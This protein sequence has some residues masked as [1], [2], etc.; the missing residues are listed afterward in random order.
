ME[1]F[2]TDAVCCLGE[3]TR[4]FWSHAQF[5]FRLREGI[6]ILWSS[7]NKSNDILKAFCS[8]CKVKIPHKNS[9]A[10][11]FKIISV[12]AAYN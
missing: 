9:F 12:V 7:L 10:F 4:I 5:T 6:P 8:F 2:S 3:S 11:M 1:E